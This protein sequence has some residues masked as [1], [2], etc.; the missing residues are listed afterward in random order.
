MHQEVGYHFLGCLNRRSHQ[1]QLSKFRACCVCNFSEGAYHYE[2]SCNHSLMLRTLRNRALRDET[3]SYSDQSHDRQNDGKSLCRSAKLILNKPWQYVR[4]NLSQIPEFLIDMTR[5][6]RCCCAVSGFR[7][8]GKCSFSITFFCVFLGL[9][10]SW[11]AS[12]N[13]N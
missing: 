8:S 3:K 5:I 1:W 2:S 6:T 7:K 11:Y 9:G 4:N 13:N 12:K 10:S